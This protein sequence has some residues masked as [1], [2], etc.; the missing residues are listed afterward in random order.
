MIHYFKFLKVQAEC[1]SG[2]KIQSTCPVVSFL[3]HRSVSRQVQGL[4]N[5]LGLLPENNGGPKAT[6]L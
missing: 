6:L 1:Q 3:C 4:H 5:R 2:E